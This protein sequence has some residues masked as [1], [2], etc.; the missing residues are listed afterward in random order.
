MENDMS[1]RGATRAMRGVAEYIYT[2]AG[3]YEK[4]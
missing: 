1:G 2:I 3:F 4:S